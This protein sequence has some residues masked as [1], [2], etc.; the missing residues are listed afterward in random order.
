[1]PNLELILRIVPEADVA[2]VRD[3]LQGFK[4]NLTDIGKGVNLIDATKLD[5]EIKKV[6]A[7]FTSGKKQAV[8][9]AVAWEKFSAIASGGIGRSKEKLKE[10]NQELRNQLIALKTAGDTGSEEYK[11]IQNQIMANIRAMKDADK[12]SQQ[13]V[14]SQGQVLNTFSKLANFGLIVQGVQAL[15]S[16]TQG[17]VQ[18][19]TQLDTATQSI[20]TLGGA[21]KENAGEF[22]NLALEMSKK[23]PIGAEALQ[24]STYDALSAG[25]NATKEDIGSFMNAASQLAVGGGEQVGNTVN[26]L[27]SLLNAYGLAASETANVS[28][29]LFTTVNLGKTTIP[30]LNSSLSNVIPTAAAVGINLKN[31]GAS[32][33][34]MTANG[35][36]TAQSTTKLNQLFI[37]LQKPGSELAKVLKAAGVSTKDLAEKS[38][39][40]N[41]GKIKT[42]LDKMGTSATVAFS[43][44]EAGSAFNVLTK[45]IEKYQDTL[46]SFNESSGA[47]EAA[48]DEMAGTLENRAASIKSAINTFVIEG[49]DSLGGFGA[50]MVGVVNT[51]SEVQGPILALAGLKQIIP[52]GS[53]QAVKNLAV[54]IVAGL[55]PS[56]GAQVAATGAA[57]VSMGALA[58]ATW[59]ALSPMLPFIALI[60]LVGT[61]A[62]A[63]SGGFDKTAESKIKDAEASENLINKQIEQ[64]N[65]NKKTAESTIEMAK[66]W[67]ELGKIQTKSPAEL[68]EYN[69]L[70]LELSKRLPG[71]IDGNKDFA[72]NLVNV[73]K[74]LGNTKNK[75]SE[76]NSQLDTLAKQ[77]EQI[78][79]YKVQLNAT[80]AVGE[81]QVAA[82][83]IL[84]GFF[85]SM[86]DIKDA[87]LVK[88]LIY[89]LNQAKNSD[90]L[91]KKQ[92]ELNNKIM[93]FNISE[94]EKLKLID[95]TEKV[96][97]ARNQTLDRYRKLD[98]QKRKEQE[99]K[100]NEEIQKFVVASNIP[101]AGERTEN[102]QKKLEAIIQSI[103]IKFNITKDEAA[104]LTEEMIK[105]TAEAGK[106]AE[107]VKGIN[108]S[109]DETLKVAQTGFN[110]G[111][112]K[113]L[114]LIL[115]IRE[116]RKQGD[117]GLAKQYESELAQ[118]R[119]LTK[120][121][122]NQQDALEKIKKS[123][124][125]RYEDKKIE[126]FFDHQMKLYE[127]A[128][129]NYDLQVKILSNQI[130]SK[131]IAEKR[132][133]TE[134]ESL[135]IQ[136]AKYSAIVNQKSALMSFLKLTQ[137][138]E[139]NVVFNPKIKI[140]DEQRLKL[141]TQVAD[142][143]KSLNDAAKSITVKPKMDPLDLELELLKLQK[144]NIQ[145]QIEAGL[146]LP[147][148]IEGI[149][150][151]ELQ[152]LNDQLIELQKK[153]NNAKT[154]NERQQLAVDIEK[155]KSQILKGEKEIQDD[156][157]TLNDKVLTDLQDQHN[158]ELDSIQKRFDA[159]RQITETMSKLINDTAVKFVDK[160]YNS[161]IKKL[162][163]LKKANL[164]TEDDYNRLKEEKE[165]EHQ[166]KIKAIQDA[167]RGS[168]IEAEREQTLKLLEEKRKR[169]EAELNVTNPDSEQYKKLSEELSSLNDEINDK[170][171]LLKSYS[172]ELQTALTDTFANLIYFDEEGVKKPFKQLF[173]VLGGALKKF[174]SVIITEL[175]FGEVSKYSAT[176]LIALVA[177]PAFQQI[178]QLALGKILDPI[179][180]SI[181]SFATGGP[182]PTGYYE[183]PT[184]LVGDAQ[185][186]NFSGK[187]HE[188]VFNEPNIWLL[189]SE[190][191]KE[192]DNQSQ[193]EKSYELSI[194]EL[195]LNMIQLNRSISSL[196]PFLRE[197]DITINKLSSLIDN[198]NEIQL[199][200]RAY[201]NN[202]ISETVYL[203]RVNRS[204]KNIVSFAEGSDFIYH[205]TTAII[206]DA[207]Q[208]NPEIVLNNPQLQ[209]VIDQS[210]RTAS[211]AV[212]KKLDIMI[213]KLDLLLR[214]DPDIYLDK[215]KVT[216]E[217]N[218]ENN[219][220]KLR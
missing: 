124:T 102:D 151:R 186:Y 96:A 182:V 160:D 14:Q 66:K 36:P 8:D 130:E 73:Q 37:E 142:L 48:F 94:E 156:R 54:N 140:N 122:N 153:Y 125:S 192:Y 84:T 67:E 163:D 205:P 112:K 15:T 83:D 144:E 212:E 104:K 175:V 46:E 123:E 126:S 72:D 16:S 208:N 148:G 169:V 22:R 9:S 12:S 41:L 20:K 40:E 141:K 189:I 2:R 110:E 25:I 30:E 57:S 146:V 177:I 214:K 32:L 180:A 17:L 10:L 131:A 42:T 172:G 138:N 209:A 183:S 28:D 147:G 61:A 166:Q 44:S 50:G 11:K 184:I 174:L 198:Y 219:R 135:A 150:V 220:R 78:I 193:P 114:D 51:L 191:L 120:G 23:Y 69:N 60:G 85:S 165:Q 155:K 171:N 197:T 203:E 129:N 7:A 75:I 178:A 24:K 206:G 76:F 58:S 49:L 63:L 133:L 4:A 149:Q 82:Q 213:N 134:A 62:Y 39:P 74:A 211:N 97:A 210:A 21:A 170:G 47:T 98:E 168:E 108:I 90:E 103:A 195:S 115:K 52:S 204:E 3:M 80:K 145:I 161:Q 116:A 216:D 19:F 79:T 201:K 196:R 179:I 105:Q 29:T 157:K 109:F 113:S 152:I 59:T 92:I 55:V 27:S 159:E 187:N 111:F 95:A 70:T 127:N 26:L 101:L 56:L 207:G 35:V 6:E 65:S 53:V 188:W 38:L 81:A 199:A 13:S 181:T 87:E 117:K 215:V 45:D 154:E 5:A 128:K 93:S 34:L 43:S 106:T 137:D 173:N 164:L 31:V 107:A 162:D 99:K 100:I 200:D 202:E 118:Q 136:N 217:I 158:K 89:N 18:P 132:E 167:V 77:K 68:K 33:A 64:I 1:M 190:V 176:G 91:Q 119:K 139:G 71:A 88:S 121:F 194:K 143:D 86:K 218:R 185:N